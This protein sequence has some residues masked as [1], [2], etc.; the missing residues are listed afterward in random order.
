MGVKYGKPYEEIVAELSEAIGGAEG[1][2]LLFEMS[3]GEWLELAVEEREDCLRTMA[4]DIFYGLG[5]EPVLPLGGGTI[6]YDKMNHVIKVIYDEQ[7]TRLV[8]LV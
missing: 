8:R 5:T 7:V 1:C 2:H 6:V 3:R 4:D